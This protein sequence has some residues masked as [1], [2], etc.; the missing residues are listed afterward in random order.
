MIAAAVLE[1][2]DARDGL[3]DS[4]IGDARRCRFNPRMLQC[5]G[6]DR[7]NCLT[8]G[9][10]RTLLKIYGGA[11]TSDQ[12]QI[13]EMTSLRKIAAVVTCVAVICRAAIL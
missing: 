5:A 6:G 13:N 10:V 12:E 2:C 11:V 1:E 3:R 9:E 4:L 7:P 8:P